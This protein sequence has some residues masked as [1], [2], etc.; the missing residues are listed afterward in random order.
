[1]KKRPLLL[2]VPLFAALAACGADEDEPAFD[3]ALS[4][5]PPDVASAEIEWLPAA[6]P[7]GNARLQLRFADGRRGTR[8]AIDGG[9]GP[10]LL[11]DDGSGPDAQAGDGLYAA[12]VQADRTRRVQQQ[13]RLHA[14]AARTQAVPEFLFRQRVGERAAMPPAP[15][16]ARLA[17]EPLRGEPGAVDPERELLVRA[18]GVVEDPQRTFEPCTGAGTP[19]GAWTFGRLVTEI[20][21]QP[22]TG[23][24]PA[25]FA[26]AWMHQWMQGRTIN[27][28]AVPGRAAGAQAFLDG[29]PRL[30]DGRLDLA[31]APFRL[32]AIVNR[33]DL[34][35]NTLFGPSN[36]AEARF[37]FGG[38]ACAPR[39]DQP[40]IETLGFTVILEYAVPAADCAGVRGWAQQWRALGALPLGSPAYNAALQAI[41]DQFSLR[42]ARP[43]RAPNF[44]AL[45]QVRS[46]E[47]AMADSPSE[48]FWE[49][50]ES[51]LARNG[52]LLH[53]T[54]V[55]TPDRSLQGSTVLRDFVNAHEAKILAGGQ[56]VPTQF[57]AGV[58]F[59]G[60][61][62][63]QGAGIAWDAPGIANPEARYRFSVG[64][65]N[66]C[67]TQETGTRFVHIE[68]RPRGAVARLSRFLT[69]EGMP[70]NDPVS[71]APRHF[72]DLLE[73]AL[74]LDADAR[75]ACEARGEA[76]LDELFM[77]PLPPAF[78]H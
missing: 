11:R 14:M 10:T 54:L 7:E 66:A 37:V 4:R 13:Q 26:E 44:S 53:D 74:R 39:P 59:L 2:L 18:L 43:E 62:F 38:V 24:D 30:A 33:L 6:G 28:F 58:P 16:G 31:R 1:M 51:R 35:G 50:R 41:T 67:H 56:G 76:A 8:L 73:R 47:F 75:L 69:G 57:P 71:G 20:A 36:S 32:L 78:V 27:G 61:H 49:L 21:N 60:G 34:R 55:Q 68:P 22:A 46:N 5:L 15:S 42:H 65:C 3:P 17:L 48:I 29:W 45:Q 19:M 63:V 64:T 23:V 12:W 72:N 40:P 25:A 9:H 77:R 52:Q 70:V